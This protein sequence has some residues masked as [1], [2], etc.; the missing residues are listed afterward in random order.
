MAA[1]QARPTFDEL[2]LQ[3][4]HPRRSAWGLYGSDDELGTLNLLNEESAKS[5]AQEIRLG[6]V[7]PLKWVCRS[8]A[9]TPSF[10]DNEAH[11][12]L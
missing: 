2:P 5:A 4:G 9:G 3:P 1:K 10:T 11:C 12:V 6:I 8:T 7:C